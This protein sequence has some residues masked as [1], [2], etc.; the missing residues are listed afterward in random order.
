MLSY[1]QAPAFASAFGA[2]MRAVSTPFRNL[3]NLADNGGPLNKKDM[4]ALWDV[5]QPGKKFSLRAF[6]NLVGQGG[7]HGI[8][9]VDIPVR[10]DI[11]PYVAR[12]LYESERNLPDF[13]LADSCAATGGIVRDD[14]LF[15]GAVQ[16][17]VSGCGVG[18]DQL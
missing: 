15:A 1:D 10:T 8:R 7:A 4:V 13:C 12:D 6:V 2:I 9:I 5:L 3:A 11:V 17:G 16:F 14:E 18:R